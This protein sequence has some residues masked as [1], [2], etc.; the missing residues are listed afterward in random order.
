LFYYVNE[1][2]LLQKPSYSLF[3][4]LLD[5]YNPYTGQLE[6]LSSDELYEIDQYLDYVL[7]TPVMVTLITFLKQKGY[8]S[9]DSVFRDL[10]DELWFQLYP[11]S[12]SG[13]VDS[14]G[15]EHVMVGE[16]EPSSVTGF[17]NWFRF[18]QLEKAGS[19]TY[20]GFILSVDTSVGY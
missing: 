10:L 19:L 1:A 18:Y 6:T 15:F 14:S 17:H 5:N 11:R 12:S 2:S 4:S 20:T 16:L 7:T 8:T 3:F 9:S 13:P